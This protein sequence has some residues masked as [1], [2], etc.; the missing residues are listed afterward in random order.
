[1]DRGDRGVCGGCRWF[2]LDKP[3]RR[4][5]EGDCYVYPPAVLAIGG[6]FL[7]PP[8][9]RHVRPRVKSDDGCSLYQPAGGLGC[10]A[11]DVGLD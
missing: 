1:M 2:R 5:D 9:I 6:G 7:T 4:R 8:H 3:G 11:A 10:E